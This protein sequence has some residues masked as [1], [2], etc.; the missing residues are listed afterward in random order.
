[1][2][3]ASAP[4][5]FLEYFKVP[6]KLVDPHADLGAGANSPGSLEC[7]TILSNDGPSLRWP[8]F[9]VGSVCHRGRGTSHSGLFFLDSLRLYGHV[10]SDSLAASALRDGARWTAVQTLTNAEGTRI[11]SVWRSDDGSYFLPFDPDEVIHNFWSESYQL[12]AESQAL[13][14]VKR[15]ARKTYYRVKPAIP[16]SVQIRARRTLRVVQARSHFPRW[17]VETALHDFYDFLLETLHELAASPVPWLHWWPD[18]HAWAFVLTHDV[19]TSFGY[20]HVSA[21]ASLETAA[22]VRSSWNF[23]PARYTVD[24]TL[25]A[26]LKEAGFEVGVHGLH[27]DG[28]DLASL[29]VL[30]K[31]L[32]AMRHYAGRWGATGFRSPA[33]HRVWEWMPLLGFDYDSSYPDTDPFEPQ[34]GGCC[35]WLPYFN[36]DLV[37]LP[38]T[39]P[40]DHTLFAILGHEDE[41]AWR[42]KA[43]FLREREGM[44]LV[45]THPDYMTEPQH[46][47][48][49]ERLLELYAGDNTAWKPLPQ[50]VSAWWR[51]R[52]A[53]Q[54]RRGH[55]GWTVAG[56][57][58]GHATVRLTGG[59]Y[60]LSASRVDVC[61]A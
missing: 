49:Y 41:G 40:Q 9:S 45:I 38:I 46:L 53:S 58:A 29:R 15:L 24:D 57:A 26:E 30:Q 12:V 18:H 7:V 5:G 50:D 22:G 43:D 4:V 55:D 32:P 47:D 21:L 13:R 3:T 23:V 10:L 31:R 52:A 11:A 51:R 44:A 36:R 42:E 39:L 27:H 19:E 35:T 6:H 33:T 60:S 54:I 61:G 2:F 48:A 37:E 14:T 28:R 8:Q 34:G 1:M 59:A 20:R 16:R 17:P 56:P 25:V